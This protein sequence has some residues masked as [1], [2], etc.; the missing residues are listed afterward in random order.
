MKRA[1]IIAVVACACAF[2]ACGYEEYDDTGI[3]T[4]LNDLKDRVSELEKLCTQINSDIA[5]LRTILNALEKNDFITDISPLI[6]DGKEVGYTI[7]FAKSGT[8]TI[9][10]GK[11]GSNG[12]DGEDGY[13]PVVGIKQASDNIYYWTVDG[14]WLLDDS[15]NKIKAGGTD[16]SDGT[17]GK[18]GITP[19]LKIENDSWYVSYD[20]GKSWTELGK[21][22][23]EG[24]SGSAGATGPQGPQGPQGEQGPQGPQGEKGEKGDSFFQT[25]MQDDENVYLVLADG[26]TISIP[27]AS[28]SKNIVLTYIPRYSDGKATVFFSTKEN[29]YVEFNF[30]V[31]PASVAANWREDA[32]VK[33]V[34]TETRAGVE[35]I[36][37]AILDWEADAS[38]GTITVKASGANLSDEFFAGEQEA[39]ARLVV[40]GSDVN[41]ISEYIPMIATQVEDNGNDDGDGED[42]GNG[43]N[44]GNDEGEGDDDGDDDTPAVTQPNNEI[45][46]TTTDNSEITVANQNAFGA[47]IISTSYADGKGVILC[48]GDITA[49]GYNAF[50]FRGNLQSI[51]LPESVTSIGE[52]AFYRCRSLQEITLPEGVTEI[53]EKAFYD[54]SSL[55]EITIPENIT[56]IGSYAFYNCTSI[57]AFYGK[58]ASNDNYCLVVDGVLNSFA[59]GCGVTQY[60]IPNYVTAIG[61]GA[62]YNCSS[63]Q[64]VTLPEGVQNIGQQAF[65][66]CNNIKEIN[67]PESVTMIDAKAFHSCVN[68]LSI[69]I[70]ADVATIGSYAFSNCENCAE[71]YFKST[72]PPSVALDEFGDWGALNGISPYAKIYVPI[73]SGNYYKGADYWSEYAEIIEEE[74]AF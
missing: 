69:S 28:N 44:D 70:P 72:Y 38:K 5:S 47:T 10:H 7:T 30:E 25:V 61:N 49:I 67:I 9:N 41:L 54:C 50:G 31:S 24:T 35:F 66:G 46:Y 15:G 64:S 8:I 36:D 45:W 63:L 3:R 6:Q 43:E 34:Y 16:G 21:A 68:L 27:K 60:N 37:M 20:D 62:F 39:S 22:T 33:A 48:D 57:G 2:V 13:T 51:T 59:N 23:S 1:L 40:N 53:G 55:Q 14:E 12:T 11:D 18:D 71:I 65:E 74:I 42:N 17:D 26:T 19:K 29:S 4:E 73:G 56:S 32:T 52:K 58:F